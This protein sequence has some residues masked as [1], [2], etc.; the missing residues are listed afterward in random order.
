MYN[1]SCELMGNL[2]SASFQAAAFAIIT[3]LYVNDRF[4]TFEQARPGK[5]CQLLSV[6]FRPH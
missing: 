2:G 3:E 1:W 6:L 5:F 4:P